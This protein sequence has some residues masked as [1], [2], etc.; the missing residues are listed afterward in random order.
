M[1]R[2]TDH[3]GLVISTR[4][5]EA[6]ARYAEGVQLL[7]SGS[8]AAVPVLQAALAADPSLGVLLV[9]IA[10]TRLDA[11]RAHSVDLDV[12]EL[13]LAT[14]SSA[15]RRERQHIEIVMVALRGDIA[16]ARALG[17]EHLTEFPADVLIGHL[18]GR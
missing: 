3:M 6:A 16:R 13:A 10:M 15:T 17:A 2:Y 5:A 18:V 14:S 7:I 4:S 8:P 12:L 9:A 1:L 11:E